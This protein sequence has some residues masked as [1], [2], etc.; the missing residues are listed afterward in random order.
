MSDEE[1]HYINEPE[2][3]ESRRKYQENLNNIIIN[4]ER[5]MDFNYQVKDLDSFE[6]L[7]D[8]LEKL[9]NEESKINL[10]NISD[11]ADHSLKYKIL[12]EVSKEKYGSME[13]DNPY[14]YCTMMVSLA[15]ELW[16]LEYT[17]RIVSENYYNYS[18]KYFLN[19]YFEAKK[20]VLMRLLK[21]SSFLK[22]F[23]NRVK[24]QVIL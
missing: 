13:I 23:L 10:N 17:K 24:W 9:K 1:Y 21:I 20:N 7:N 12:L 16:A 3:I 2:S 15:S 19:S 11:V 22:L 5:Y 6:K 18:K 8:Y 4:K 14:R